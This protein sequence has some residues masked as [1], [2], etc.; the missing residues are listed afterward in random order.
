ICTNSGL[1]ALA[2]TIH[3]SLLGGV[4]LSRLARINHARAR[5]LRDV[6]TA[7]PGVEVLT[8][9]FFN[10]FAIR[11]P[12]SAMDIVDALAAENGVLAGVPFA[13]L[14]P[15]AGLDY[16]LLACATETTTDEDIKALA[17]ALSRRIAR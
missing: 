7:I 11:L 2:F 1:C 13:R 6:L 16:V 17:S 4:G 14:D 15:A 12:G 3:M 9:R 8:A 10:E 5:R